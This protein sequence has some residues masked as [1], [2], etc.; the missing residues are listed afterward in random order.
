MRQTVEGKCDVPLETEMLLAKKCARKTTMILHGLKGPTIN[1]PL[2]PAPNRAKFKISRNFESNQARAHTLSL[3][4]TSPQTSSL[5]PLPPS[6]PAPPPPQSP[7]FSPASSPLTHHHLDLLSFLP[8]HHHRPTTTM[9][10]SPASYILSSQRTTMTATPNLPPPS[11]SLL[12]HR[13]N[14]ISNRN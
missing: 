1:A 13:S 10:S 2:L 6:Q 5:L 4:K 3:F 14:A 9:I 7:L 12:P 8:P 11:P